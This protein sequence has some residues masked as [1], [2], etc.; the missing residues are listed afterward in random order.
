MHDDKAFARHP[1][2][3][4]TQNLNQLHYYWPT[5]NRDVGD[6]EKHC[7]SCAMIK[8]QTV[9]LGLPVTTAL[10]QVRW[11]DICR[12]Y[13]ETMRMIKYLLLFIDHFSR[14]PEAVPTPRQDASTVTCPLVTEIFSSHGCPQVLSRGKGSN[15]M[16]SLF[17]EMYTSKMLNIKRINSTL[18]IPQMQ[19]KV[20]SFTWN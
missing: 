1:E 10:F 2:I 3:K 4:T 19:G 13:K 18:F 14:Y 12:R 8:N 6:Y 5:F 20:E 15:F 16:S 11:I 17:L 7:E 9:P